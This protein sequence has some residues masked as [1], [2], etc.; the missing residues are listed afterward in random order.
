[1]LF[2]DVVSALPAERVVVV[3][4]SGTHIGMTPT[5]ARAP[6][7]QRAFATSLRN[8]GCNL[9]LLSGLRL[10]GMDASM[11]IEGA[12][13][14]A[15]FETYVRQVLSPTL[16]PGDIVVLDNL[17]CHKS[18]TVE[19]LIADRGASILWL[20]AYSPDFSPIEHAFSKLKTFL[21]RA[22]AE[23]LDALIDAI[24]RGFATITDLDAIGWFTH[25][26]FLNL[27]QSS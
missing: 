15:V 10:T 14:S 7:G 16:H 4:E 18:P 12:V 26:G 23:T 9:T 19:V 6:S 1:M 21:R 5:H 3:D 22:K 25:C 11:V 2:A 17:S 24:T 13:D 8:Y 27:D 20:P